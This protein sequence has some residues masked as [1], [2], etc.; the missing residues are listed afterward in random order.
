MRGAPR[1]AAPLVLTYPQISPLPMATVRDV[2]R[3][4]QAEASR[5]GL[6]PQ[7]L[8]ARAHAWATA[9]LRANGYPESERPDIVSGYRSPMYQRQL[10]DRWDAGDREGLAARP[11][12]QSWHMARRA[13]DVETGVE[14]FGLYRWL[15]EQH[16]GARWGGRFDPPD[17]PHFA[18]PVPNEKPPSIC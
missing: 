6:R 12:C 3:G 10:R 4:A 17:E 9:V 7:G 2:W 14:A 8:P 5:N 16:T 15:L 1:R 11:A 18:W 13:I